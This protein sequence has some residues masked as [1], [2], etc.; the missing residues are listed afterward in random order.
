MATM[1]M[2]ATKSTPTVLQMALKEAALTAFLIFMLSFLMIGFLTQANQGQQLSFVTRF[3]AIA[4]G[5]LLVPLGRIALVYDRHG[6]STPALI[7]GGI[8]FVYLFGGAV[9]TFITGVPAIAYNDYIM[10][11][12]TPGGIPMPFGDHIV[13]AIFGLGGLFLVVKALQTKRIAAQGGLTAE[14]REAKEE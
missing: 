5:I 12:A 10:G 4:W 3:G 11:V 2:T 13:D 14:V 9:V 8:A 6:Q 7:G 1:T